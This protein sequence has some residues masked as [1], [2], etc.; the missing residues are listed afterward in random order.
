MQ[1]F[2]G[3]WQWSWTA[4][5]CVGR[6]DTFQGT[7]QLRVCCHSY[8]LHCNK[9]KLPDQIY[10]TLGEEKSTRERENQEKNKICILCKQLYRGYSQGKDNRIIKNGKDH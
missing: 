10:K 1:I 3:L 4:S 9:C 8:K 6:S 7:H 5:L 2:S